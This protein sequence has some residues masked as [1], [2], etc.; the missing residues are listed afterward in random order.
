M[1]GGSA[2]QGRRDH[3]S[4]DKD[5]AASN[6]R[7]AMEHRGILLMGSIREGR[8]WADTV[9]G[10]GA[11]FSVAL[12]QRGGSVSGMGPISVRT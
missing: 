7:V 2:S 3:T 8:G 9:Q 1:A 5:E 4:E 10:L 12:Y 11:F 6:K